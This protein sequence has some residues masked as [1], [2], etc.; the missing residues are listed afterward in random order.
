MIKTEKE[1]PTTEAHTNPEKRNNLTTGRLGTK[2][3]PG[4]VMCLELHWLYFY[5]VGLEGISQTE[6]PADKKQRP[7][8]QAF[9]P[10]LYKMAQKGKPFRMMA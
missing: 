3:R 5:A 4:R 10:G 9:M 6:K 2:L 8:Q 1:G 7:V